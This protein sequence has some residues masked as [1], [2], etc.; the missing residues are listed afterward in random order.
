MFGAC[1]K[2]P[3]TCEGCTVNGTEYN[4]GDEFPMGTCQICQCHKDESTGEHYYKCNPK[5]QL[6]GD[7]CA[8][9][10]TIHQFPLLFT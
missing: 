2:T 4:N 1:Y 8:K 7:D 9:V 5:C 6:T 10:M 3:P